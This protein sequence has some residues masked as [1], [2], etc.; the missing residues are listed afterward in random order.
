M[1]AHII[2]SSLRRG[3][4]L[5]ILDEFSCRFWCLR[6]QADFTQPQ[7]GSLSQSK[8]KDRVEVGPSPHQLDRMRDGT[9]SIVG[10]RQ[11]FHDVHHTNPRLKAES[12]S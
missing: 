8:D 1:K 6:R 3:V 10:W 9:V 7:A 5:R 11:D 12:F 2:N 4:C